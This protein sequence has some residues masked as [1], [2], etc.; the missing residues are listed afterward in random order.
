MLPMLEIEKWAREK[1]E[2]A[3]AKQ[4]QKQ[5][6]AGGARATEEGDGVGAGG[7][8]GGGGVQRTATDG[9]F[10]RAKPEPL[11][12]FCTYFFLFFL[13]LTLVSSCKA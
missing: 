9:W 1:N 2:R 10:P 13:F 5:E 8:G 12:S 3:A 7:V 6:T 11:V 4:K